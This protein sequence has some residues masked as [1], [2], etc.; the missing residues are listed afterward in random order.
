MRVGKIALQRCHYPLR[1]MSQFRAI[2]VTGARK[3]NAKFFTDSSRGW[4]HQENPVGETDRFANVMGDEDDRL[5]PPQDRA[6]ATRCF[7]PPDNSWTY[8]FLYFSSPTNVR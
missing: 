2:D 8:A 5:P 4:R 1:N 3:R 6:S 7:M